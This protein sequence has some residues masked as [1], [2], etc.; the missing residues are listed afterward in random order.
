[1][2]D[3]LITIKTEEKVDK[4]ERIN[5]FEYFR[6][7]KRITKENGTHGANNKLFKSKMV[8]KAAIPAM[9]YAS[10]LVMTNQMENKL[11][12]WER[13]ILRKMLER[14]KMENCGWTHRRNAEI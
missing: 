1:M 3:T 9:V 12:M 6:V 8:S 13:W 14:V 11:E 7:T 2:Y 4:F 10:E 5:G